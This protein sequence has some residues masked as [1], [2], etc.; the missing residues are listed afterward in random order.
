MC[1]SAHPTKLAL[2]NHI[3]E[4]QPHED[5]VGSRAASFFYRCDD[6]GMNFSVRYEMRQHVR[7]VHRPAPSFVCGECE[8]SFYN[9]RNL[10]Q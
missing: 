1:D 2:F 6:C 8:M 3:Q 9:A 10:G 4:H 7:R 5:N